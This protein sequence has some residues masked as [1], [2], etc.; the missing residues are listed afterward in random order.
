[1]LGDSLLMYPH[2]G[3]SDNISVWCSKDETTGALWQRYCTRSDNG[4]GVCD[5]HFLNDNISIIAGIPGM[6]SGILKG[7]QTPFFI[8]YKIFTTTVTVTMR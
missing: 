8:Y 4:T 1:M 7:T 2:E 3:T 6:A 5:D